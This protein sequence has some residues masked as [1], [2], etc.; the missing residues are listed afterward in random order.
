MSSPPKNGTNVNY[1]RKVGSNVANTSRALKGRNTPTSLNPIKH[2]V[3]ELSVEAP[4]TAIVSKKSITRLSN[5]TTLPTTSN[6][7]NDH[8][9]V[10]NAIQVHNGNDDLNSTPAGALEDSRMAMLD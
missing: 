3:M 9:K 1:S 8:G 4:P 6:L 10:E 2:V 5:P 7:S